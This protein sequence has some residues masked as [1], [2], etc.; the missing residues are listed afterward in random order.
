VPRHTFCLIVLLALPPFAAGSQ[1][2]RVMPQPTVDGADGSAGSVAPDPVPVRART[3]RRLVY[4]CATPTLVTFA[5]R[6]CGAQPVLRELKVQSPARAAGAAPVVGAAASAPKAEPVHAAP[7]TAADASA[8]A[9]ARSS[10]EAIPSE[11][12]QQEACRKLQ[13]RLDQVDAVM[14]AGYSAAQAG[15]LWDRWREAKSNLREARC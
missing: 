5:D 4:S 1:D 14:R 12:K 8:Q 15:R 2:A 6:P 9:S 10:H 7:R 3:T 11:Q 13:A